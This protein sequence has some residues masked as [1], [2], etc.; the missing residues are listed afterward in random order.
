M[1]VLVTDANTR[2]ALAV[3]RSLGRAGIC[4]GVGDVQANTLAGASKYCSVVAALPSQP[5]PL[6]RGLSWLSRKVTRYV[7]SLY[8]ASCDSTLSAFV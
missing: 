3:V 5:G 2:S 1:K 4:V 6:K 7:A 8:F